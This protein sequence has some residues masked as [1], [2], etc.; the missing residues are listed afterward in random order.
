MGLGYNCEVNRRYGG[1]GG[2]S[3]EWE[4]SAKASTD[5]IRALEALEH[6]QLVAFHFYYETNGTDG[7]CVLQDT[8]ED[9]VTDLFL[10]LTAWPGSEDEV[11]E[12]IKAPR[13]KG[14]RDV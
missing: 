13:F 4:F 6:P 12:R 3:T 5:R 1:H 7:F 14:L 8:R 11:L 10:Y 9:L 2:H